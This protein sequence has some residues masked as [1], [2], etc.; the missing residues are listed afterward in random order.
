MTSNNHKPTI[1]RISPV[2]A[3]LSALGR[4]MYELACELYPI[5]RSL[6][7]AGTRKSLDLIRRVIPL[8]LH[9]VPTGTKV[10]DWTIPNEWNIREA[11]VKDS[12]GARLLISQRAI[13][14][15]SITATRF[16]HAFR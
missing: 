13:Y 14:I 3:G 10:L 15:S 7:G 5:C 12:S 6:T 8:E 16:T 11:W 1:A 9:E 2:Q 4:S